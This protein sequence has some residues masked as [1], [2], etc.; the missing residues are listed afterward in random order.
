[1]S[2]YQKRRTE[3]ES[4]RR[5]NVFSKEGIPQNKAG[6]CFGDR[7]QHVNGSHY[8]GQL[9]AKPLVFQNNT[10]F[11]PWECIFYGQALGFIINDN[12]SKTRDAS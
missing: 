2:C 10:G 7:L 5:S 4:Q 3:V 9:S 12:L 1:M 6:L 11:F 8:S